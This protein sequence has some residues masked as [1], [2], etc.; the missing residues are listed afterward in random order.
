MP[1]I[2]IRLLLRD[3]P[4]SSMN[5]ILYLHSGLFYSSVECFSAFFPSWIPTS[6]KA[7]VA[8]E[9]PSEMQIGRLE[10]DLRVEQLVDDENFLD[11]P[12]IG[13]NYHDMIAQAPHYELETSCTGKSEG[14][15]TKII[16]SRPITIVV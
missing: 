6:R 12:F 3:D 4:D 13:G 16:L 1:T 8:I 7:S 10:R 14:R 9:P 15:R 11:E 5:T 2:L